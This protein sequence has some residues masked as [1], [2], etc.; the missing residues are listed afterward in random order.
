MKVKIDTKEKMHV[1]TIHEPDIAANMTEKMDKALTALLDQNVKN[2]VINMQD[3]KKLDNAAAACFI[4][5]QHLFNERQASFVVCN[6]QSGVKEL[7]ASRDLLGQLNITHTESEAMDI[8]QMEE[9]EREIG[10]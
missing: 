8:V 7:L 5:L 6:L 2:V 3:I 1:I 10:L 4:K 9:L